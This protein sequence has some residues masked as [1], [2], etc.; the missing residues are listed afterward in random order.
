HVGQ[1]ALQDRRTALGVG[2]DDES[3]GRCSHGGTS[4][5]LVAAPWVFRSV[6]GKVTGDGCG[7]S[8]ARSRARLNPNSWW[9]SSVLATMPSG[10]TATGCETSLETV[11]LNPVG[12]SD[13][14]AVPG[15]S[16]DHARS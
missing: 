8:P 2:A 16:S 15:V 9:T 5:H 14:G 4:F 1:S 6:W 10:R 13:G 11:T 12:R 7:R 3:V